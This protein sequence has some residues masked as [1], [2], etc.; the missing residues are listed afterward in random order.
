[1]LRK[2]IQSPIYLAQ[3]IMSRIV[4]LL[5][6]SLLPAALFYSRMEATY[7]TAFLVSL[8]LIVMAVDSGFIV[9]A[10]LNATCIRFS[11]LIWSL[12]GLIEEQTR[13][14]YCK[15]KDGL[16]AS[17]FNAPF[18]L[19][20]REFCQGETSSAKQEF[21]YSSHAIINNHTLLLWRRLVIFNEITAQHFVCKLFG[22]FEI[23]YNG[24]LQLNHWI[25]SAI[26]FAYTQ[27]F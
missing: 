17:K 21:E 19:K 13:V 9:C 27:N 1:M 23:N 24:V 7:L 4:I 5:V 6:L 8:F 18:D 14:R 26:L 16:P 3:C 20:C 11:N 2:D 22:C 15:S 25:L 12:I 10:A